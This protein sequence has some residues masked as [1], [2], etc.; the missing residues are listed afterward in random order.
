[1]K[2]KAENDSMGNEEIQ[3]QKGIYEDLLEGERTAKEMIQKKSNSAI[4]ELKL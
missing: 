2:E 4:D 1:M 3:K